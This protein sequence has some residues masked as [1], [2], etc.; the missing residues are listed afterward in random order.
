MKSLI[1]YGL[2]TGFNRGGM[3]L[4]LPLLSSVLS[5]SDY[6]EF[7]LYLIIV[8]LMVPFISLNIVSIIGRE[9]YENFKITL[10]FTIYF[11]RVASVF[12]LL[13]ALLY[14]VIEKTWCQITVY[15]LMEAIFLTNSTL[16]RYKS[17]AYNYFYLCIS[18]MLVLVTILGLL[19]LFSRQKLSNI[20]HLIIIFSLSN[21][22]ILY[23]FLK[24]SFNVKIRSIR[25]Y[26]IIRKQSAIIVFALSILP[27][28]LAQWVTSGADRFFV[29]KYTSDIELGYYS[30]GY[31][32]A[33]IYML[34]NSALAL[35]IPQFCV[36]N[37]EYFKN[38]IFFSKYLVSVTFLWLLFVIA[39]NCALFF[40]PTKYNVNK[41]YWVV[42]FV[43]VGLYY[44]S[45]YYYYSS[46]LFYSRKSKT[47]SSITIAVA[48]VNIVL[49]IIFTPS[50]GIVGTALS[51]TLSYGFYMILTYYYA[52]KTYKVGSFLLPIFISI[53]LT[54]LLLGLHYCIG[55]VN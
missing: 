33:A 25:L 35:G 6:G 40:I 43:M 55:F 12:I 44:L 15:A 3:F 2:A 52:V 39:I 28:T 24:L 16:I 38:K 17:S 49:I 10:C 4:I 46:F 21:L 36:K 45:F 11:N 1:L 7:S 31:S 23:Q 19:F 5:I 41:L 26:N 53:V 22:V 54:V 8:Q 30:Y 48:I 32:I 42:Y 9:V 18:K 13:I 37:F 20:D 51:T 34:V 50:M 47:L 14:I 27:H 29:K